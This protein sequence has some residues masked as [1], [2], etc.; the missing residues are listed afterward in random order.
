M[1]L[2]H[3][4]GWGRRRV[5]AVGGGRRYGHLDSERVG[6]RIFLTVEVVSSAP[7][8]VEALVLM[9]DVGEWTY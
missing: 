8:A 5:A 6:Q 7:A 3:Q 9:T 4:L 1:R 2:R